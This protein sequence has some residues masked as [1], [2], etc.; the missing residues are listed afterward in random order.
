MSTNTI[1]K[2][3]FALVAAAGIALAGVAGAADTV[4]GTWVFYDENGV[5]VGGKT[6][7][8]PPASPSSWGVRGVSSV[9][10]PLNCPTGD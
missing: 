9:F 8:C 4:R 1:A 5:V 3:F 7:P 2:S 6:I 10:H